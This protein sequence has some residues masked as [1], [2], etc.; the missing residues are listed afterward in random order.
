MYLLAVLR[1]PIEPAQIEF[2]PYPKETLSSGLDR[3]QQETQRR[4]LTDNLAFYDL[5]CSAKGLV[6]VIMKGMLFLLLLFW[7]ANGFLFSTLSS[8]PSV[9]S[10]CSGVHC[11]RLYGTNANP[12]SEIIEPAKFNKDLYAVLGVSRKASK[13]EIRAAYM[14]IVNANHPDRNSSSEGLRPPTGLK[15]AP[16]MMEDITSR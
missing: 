3:T 8:G 16:F 10:T 9:S 7:H 4:E 5:C 12:T 15:G 6:S 2:P 13:E 1:V 11:F 14:S